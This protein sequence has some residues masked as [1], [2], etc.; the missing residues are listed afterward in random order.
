VLGEVTDPALVPLVLE[1]LARRVIPV[2]GDAT[3]D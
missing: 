3:S 2:A 1:T